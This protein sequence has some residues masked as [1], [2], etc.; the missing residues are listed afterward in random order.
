MMNIRGY[1]QILFIFQDHGKIRQALH[2]SSCFGNE[3]IDSDLV[4]VSYTPT[5]NQNKLY[6]NQTLCCTMSILFCTMLQL[7]SIKKSQ[8]FH[9]HQ[10]LLEQNHNTKIFDKTQWPHFVPF[11]HVK[12][13]QNTKFYQKFLYCDSTLIWQVFFFRK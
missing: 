4:Y 13:G 7:F 9:F 12:R 6:K 10:F 5:W 11:S 8:N 2:L 3:I 1:L